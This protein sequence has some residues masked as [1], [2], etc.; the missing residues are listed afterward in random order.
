V[1]YVSPYLGGNLYNYS[2]MTG[3][4]LIGFPGNGE[5][6]VVFDSGISH[7]AWGPVTWDCKIYDDGQLQV[8]FSASDDGTNFGPSEILAQPNAVPVSAGRF[9]KAVVTF[10]RSSAGQSPILKDI[11]LGTLGYSATL[12]QPTVNLDA[13]PNISLQLPFSAALHA[14]VW[15]NGFYNYNTNQAF[16]WSMVSGPGTIT[17]GSSNAASTT[18]QVSA[19]GVYDVRVQTTLLG[20][21]YS[22]DVS[23]DAMPINHAPWVDVGA[24]RVL[25]TTNDVLHMAA[26]AT[27]DGLPSN[28]MYLQWSEVIGPGA[29]TFSNPTSG[30]NDITFSAPGIYLLQ[31]WASDTQLSFSNQVEVRVQ[32]PCEV[33]APAGIS[34]W[35]T[36]NGSTHESIRGNDMNLYKGAGYALGQISDGFS[37]NGVTNYAEAYAHPALDVGSGG[38]MTIEFWAK[39]TSSGRLLEWYRNGVNG[40]YA[41]YSSSGTM[42]FHLVDTNR[43]DHSFSFNSGLSSSQFNHIALTYDR[44][45]AMQL[46][47]LM[48]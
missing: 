47:M 15:H 44:R 23:I 9:A 19:Q 35:W 28:I 13:G 43:I 12:V 24:T 4:T 27:D 31:L 6:S 26:I 48:A 10:V 32:C 36:G 42:T 1:D 40:V 11:T 46:S 38:A 21:V 34:Q 3:S 22:S 20:T 17:F 39:A 18:A 37:F 33:E 45:P 30:T 29:V 41:D 5:W 16:F 8:A 14:A 7:A 2:D 25:R